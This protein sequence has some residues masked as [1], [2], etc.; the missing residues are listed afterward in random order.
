[1]SVVYSA[2]EAKAK[3]AEII[4]RVR[5]GGRVTITYRG[6]PV[7]EV[8][9]VAGS[10]K[11]LEERLQR[12]VKEGSVVAARGNAELEPLALRPGALARFLAERE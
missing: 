6:E 8:G 9:P 10:T 5:D 2:Y 12:L 1:M 11:T 7:A 4:R 3:L